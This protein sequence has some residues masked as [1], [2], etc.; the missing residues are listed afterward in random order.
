MSANRP[1]RI[2]NPAPGQRSLPERAWYR[3]VQ[4]VVLHLMAS[5]G[6]LRATGRD[7]IPASGGVLLIANHLSHLDVFVL[8][9]LLRRRLNYVARS[10][11][12]KPVLGPLIRS[13]GGFPIQRDGSGAQGF[14]ETLRRLRSGEI[15][16]FFPEGTRSHDGSL[17]TLKPG[18][19]ALASRAG[20]PIV[21]TGLA[22]TFEAWPRSRR[23]PRPRAIRVHYG[24]PI[25]PERLAGLDS[26]QV[27]AELTEALRTSVA[28]AQADLRRDLRA[29][30]GLPN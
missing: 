25:P 8:G 26:E 14:R 3:L 27:L 28:R 10:S 20:V 7:N 24:Q 4:Q 5:T 17:Q 12:F 23:V 16:T 22:G 6:G 13:V 30:R 1:K 15:V 19:A 18:I 2:N 21:P 11:L 29:R 9:L